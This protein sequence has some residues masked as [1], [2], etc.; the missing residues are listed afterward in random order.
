MTSA[1]N[2]VSTSERNA[3]IATLTVNMN[4]AGAMNDNMFM[5]LKYA[6]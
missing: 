6:I 4:S 2:L 1:K 5:K 3:C